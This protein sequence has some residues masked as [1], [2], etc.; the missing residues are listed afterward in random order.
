MFKKPH[1]RT[2]RVYYLLIAY[3]SLTIAYVKALFGYTH[4]SYSADEIWT[5]TI[6]TYS[7]MNQWLLCFVGRRRRK[8]KKKKLS[9][10]FWDTWLGSKSL[11]LQR[12]GILDIQVWLFVVFWSYRDTR[13]KR[14][15]FESRCFVAELIFFKFHDCI[16]VQFRLF[17]P[18]EYQPIEGRLSIHRKEGKGFFFFF[19][20]FFF[21][22]V[23]AW[24]AGL[25]WPCEIDT[26]SNE[27][28]VQI[29]D[30]E[31]QTN[32]TA[33]CCDQ[34]LKIIIEQK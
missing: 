8:K 19:F 13:L 25:A 2:A 31:S 26:Q 7:T 20:F 33:C 5:T 23:I 15:C 22:L 17:M 3:N 16:S 21:Y 10:W 29:F 28:V 30:G 14:E 27:K 34:S 12:S 11:D 24:L 4:M 1:L 9:E 18:Q 32:F 6:Q